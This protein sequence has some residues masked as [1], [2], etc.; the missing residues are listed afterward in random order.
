[1]H[2]DAERGSG[3]Q[4]FV[5][6][7][8][9][10]PPPPA[11]TP[12]R[13]AAATPPAIQPQVPAEIPEEVC[14][15]ACSPAAPGASPGFLG[16]QVSQAFPEGCGGGVVSA[17]AASVTAPTATVKKQA[18]DTEATNAFSD[19]RIRGDVIANPLIIKML[20]ISLVQGSLVAVK[21]NLRISPDE[22]EQCP[23]MVDILPDVA[24]PG[25]E[26][27]PVD[28]PGIPPQD[29]R[30]SRCPSRCTRRRA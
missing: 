8:D 16:G 20:S 21:G 13:T 19:E 23:E 26:A 3:G 9:P 12:I 7:L 18:A 6:E 28:G 4:W 2:A 22:V 11:A 14:W 24:G 30:R 29:R 5:L 17:A 15:P 1:M 25:R 27:E 10:P